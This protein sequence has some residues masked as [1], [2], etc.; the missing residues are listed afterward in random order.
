MLLR[1]WGGFSAG[2][3]HAPQRLRAELGLHGS[4]PVPRPDS[5]VLTKA[6]GPCQ[7]FQA[8]IFEW[9]NFLLRLSWFGCSPNTP[10]R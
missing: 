6:T 5:G 7:N 2:G 8:W 1:A 3:L 4:G 9:I 10:L